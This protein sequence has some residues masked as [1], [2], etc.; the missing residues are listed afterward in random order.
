[1]AVPA[2]L[3]AGQ[4]GSQSAVSCA[5]FLQTQ[6]TVYFYGYASHVFVG[7]AQLVPIGDIAKRTQK[8]SPDHPAGE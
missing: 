2:A 5:R 7:D 8:S 6:K 3:L 1:M 4:V